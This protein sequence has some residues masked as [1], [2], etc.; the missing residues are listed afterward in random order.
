MIRAL[1]AGI[2]LGL[3]LVGTQLS[4]AE[5]QLAYRDDRSDAKA[6]I[7]S[8]YNAIN[9]HEYARAWSYWGEDD[10]SRSYDDFVKGF[11][12]TDHVDLI[13]GRVTAEGA[14]GS[15]YYSVPVALSATAGD[16]QAS[17]FAGCYTLRL[18]QPTIQEPP[19]HPLHIEKG[20]LKR[21]KGALPAN[22][23]ATCAE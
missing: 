5:D 12:H 22:L 20:N 9:R 10:P 15:T 13:V 11:A 6:L 21:V 14:A 23:P 2:L 3:T 16:G 4:M 8:Y 7:R 19:F 1:R 17:S 18:A